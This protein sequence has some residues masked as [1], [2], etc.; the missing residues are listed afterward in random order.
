MDRLFVTVLFLLICV[1]FINCDSVDLGAQMNDTVEV[2]QTTN[3]SLTKIYPNPFTTFLAD[4][5]QKIQNINGDRQLDEDILYK[6]LAG[7]PLLP[8]FVETLRTYF[9]LAYRSYI[10]FQPE[11]KF[12]QCLIK[13]FYMR[14][15]R[16]MRFFQ[17]R[18]LS[19]YIRR[20]YVAS[21]RMANNVV[22]RTIF[23][24]FV[25]VSNEYLQYKSC[26]SSQAM[27]CG[28]LKFVLS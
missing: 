3:T 25:I 12:G 1:S 11:I 24:W 2:I 6:Q 13:Y 10:L 23:K 17:W 14:F 8:P 9:K 7:F 21:G 27:H 22:T 28:L 5:N 4:L 15:P 18:N 19:V 20:L 26:A 16:V